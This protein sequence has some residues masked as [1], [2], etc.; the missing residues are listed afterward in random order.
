MTPVRYHSGRF[1][2]QDLDWQR[3]APL[4]GPAH[5]AVAGYEGML[6]GL[7]NANV[8][9]SPLASQ[10]AVLS[11][12]IEGIQTTLTELLT[13]EAEG[14]LSDAS[15]Q[16]KADVR[17]VLN[18]RL[19]LD[20]A[21]DMLK[22]IPLSQRLVRASHEILMQGVRGYNKAPGNYRRLPDTCWIGPPGSTLETA[23]YIPCPVEELRSAMD[24]LESYLHEEPLDSLVQ[25]AIVHAEFEAIHPFLDGNG[26]MGRLIVPL[27]MFT[28][29]LLS[30]PSFYISEYLE[31]HRDEYYDGLL[32]VSRDGDWT[33]WCVFF[34]TAL[35]EQARTY[36]QKSQDLLTLYSEL[37]D[38]VVEVVPSQYSGRALDW[39][40][41][42]PIFRSIDFVNGAEI[43]KSTARRLL[44]LFKTRGLL[45]ELRQG[46]GRRSSI[47]AF[48]E[49]LNIAEGRKVF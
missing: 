15:T 49:L 35:T 28:K 33:G 48:P 22:E 32:A 46:G 47:L 31:S 38:L 30:S 3:L 45:K 1:P 20:A 5:A 9:L 7:P 29:Q 13:F 17:E 10:E 2:P 6:K 27:F 42:K 23:R 39:I 4:I 24:M 8:L 11:S 34:L 41:N 40:F 18:Y 43:P 37:R 26:R 25:L 12:R 44:N 36:Q 19:A 21:I 14:N 16:A